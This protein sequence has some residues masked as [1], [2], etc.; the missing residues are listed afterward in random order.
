MIK[1]IT[2]LL[3][4]LSISSS[5][6]V[7]CSRPQKQTSETFEYFNTLCS[8]TVFCDENDFKAYDTEFRSTLKK[9]HQLFDIYNSYGD[10]I[11]LKDINEKAS[12]SPIEVSNELFDALEF[13][14]SVY[15]MTN[16]KCN[17]AIGAL[18]SIWHDARETANKSPESLVFPKDS[19]VSEALSHI[20][21]N[22][23]VLDSES[24][25]V[26]FTDSRLSLDFGAIAK[27]YVASLLYK[28]LINL[29]CQSFIVNL[30]GNNVSHGTKPDGSSWQ[31]AIE[32][33]FEDKSLGYNKII[34]L[35]DSTLVTSGTTQRFFVFDGKSY[36]HIIDPQN[37]YPSDRFALIS[38]LAD[39]SLSG[40]ADALSTALFCMSYE[41]GVSLLST[42]DGFSALWIF[43]DGSFKTSDGFGG[44]K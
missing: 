11:N 24:K 38:I 34:E 19:D 23:L 7:S 43:K 36:S 14:K 40:V 35:K 27:G 3:L 39:S 29:G 8:L 1:K 13:G 37:G 41:E 44:A 22:S 17:I 15:S 31:A 6:F 16:G 42:L 21:I 12:A 25:T 4:I 20:D 10:V 28:E 26:F 18:S 30:G 9:Y 32:N 5:F 2:A 33:P